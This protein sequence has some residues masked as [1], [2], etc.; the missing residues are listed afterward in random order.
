MEIVISLLDWA[1]FFM[2]H[3]KN[4]SLENI[5][6]EIDGV[7]VIEK[8]ININ[9]YE[10]DYMISTFGRVKSLNYKRMK[11]NV[12]ILIQCVHF[13]Y[14]RIDLTHKFNHHFVHRLVGNAFIPNPENK[15]QINH[16]KGIKTDNRVSQLEWSTF[17]EQQIH[18]Q[19][20]L[21]F[22]E[23][24]GLSK[25]MEKSKR[26]V[27]Q[28]DPITKK[29]IRT[30]SS[31]QDACRFFGLKKDAVPHAIKYKHRFAAGFKWEYA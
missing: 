22:R 26:P 18:A 2:E 11:G 13:G 30:F 12:K 7:V 5:V 3:Y 14:L 1:F 21:G 27:N 29:I 25:Q 15:P 6:E 24:D 28:L 20:V 10:G 17:S 8:W 23:I 9:G 19:S 31:Q 16:K 4:L